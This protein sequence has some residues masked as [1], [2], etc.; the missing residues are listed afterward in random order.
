MKKIL[1][2]DDEPDVNL[3]LKIVLENN[4]FKVDT[5]DDSLLALQNFREQSCLYD[6]IILYIKMPK[7]SGYE[8]YKEIRKIDDKIK[9]CFFTASEAYHEEFR[10]SVP[11][12]VWNEDCYIQK[13]INNKELIKR[14]NNIITTSSC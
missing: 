1:I 9:V 12:S 2:V 13:P 10:K 4:G 14:I 6:L 7:M 11:A 3:S 8:L 5:F